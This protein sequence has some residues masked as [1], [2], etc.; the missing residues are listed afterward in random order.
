MSRL[1]KPTMITEQLVQFEF[2]QVQVTVKFEFEFVVIF[3]FG[4]RDVVLVAELLR[5]NSAI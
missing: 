1:C 3:F 4:S 5:P 2:P